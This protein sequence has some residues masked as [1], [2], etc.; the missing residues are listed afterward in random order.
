MDPCFASSLGDFAA[1]VDDPSIPSYWV[2]SL[3]PP[4]LWVRDAD[5]EQPFDPFAVETFSGTLCFGASGTLPPVV[6]SSPLLLC[7]PEE[8]PGYALDQSGPTWQI[9]IVDEQRGADRLEAIRVA[10]R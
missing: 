6:G 1:C 4:V 8:Q 9:A 2:L 10:Y 7:R 5:L 3:N